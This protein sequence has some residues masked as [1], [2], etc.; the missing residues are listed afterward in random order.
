MTSTSTTTAAPVGFFLVEPLPPASLR[1]ARDAIF[2][3]VAAAAVAEAPHLDALAAISGGGAG[4][5]SEGAAAAARADEPRFGMAALAPP[6]APGG[7]DVRVQVRVS[8]GES[9]GLQC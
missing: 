7:G 3:T 5:A 9:C 6:K 1:R 8:K 4:G 2:A